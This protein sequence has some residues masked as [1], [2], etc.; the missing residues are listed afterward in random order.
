MSGSERNGKV[1]GGEK[2]A[3]EGL[4]CSL[5]TERSGSAKVVVFFGE[6][7]EVVAMAFFSQSACLI[8]G[9]GPGVNVNSLAPGFKL[10]AL[11]PRWSLAE[12]SLTSVTVETEAETAGAVDRGE[13]TIIS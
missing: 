12:A 13:T 1:E 7:F 4:R 11:V 2:G 6:R 3:A 10:V 8:I 9:E 5:S